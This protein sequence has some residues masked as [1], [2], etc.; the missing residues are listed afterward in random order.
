MSSKLAGTSSADSSRSNPKHDG[1]APFGSE[2][3]QSMNVES[4]RDPRWHLDMPVLNETMKI[5][6]TRYLGRTIGAVLAE[7][8]DDI[9]V[10][11]KIIRSVVASEPTVINGGALINLTVRAL[12]D[13][14]SLEQATD[15]VLRA[16]QEVAGDNNLHSHLALKALVAV[17][18]QS[19]TEMMDILLKKP[20]VG[21]ESQVCSVNHE[22]M[23]K[24]V[25]GHAGQVLHIEVSLLSGRFSRLLRSELAA[26]HFSYQE[27]KANM[28]ALGDNRD[29]HTTYAAKVDLYELKDKSSRHT[30]VKA[31]PEDFR[32]A[33]FVANMKYALKYAENIL[34]QRKPRIE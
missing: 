25:F 27:K 20:E 30:R 9:G 6:V 17:A 8:T 1:S 5:A 23:M 14:R 2:Q 21:L 16:W 28:A 10:A 12:S 24:T 33:Y 18:R 29:T 34:Q 7:T 3:L 11:T 19:C 26:A 15:N 22:S 32:Q 31:T 4:Y 13:A